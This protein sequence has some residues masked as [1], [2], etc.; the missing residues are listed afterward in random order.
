MSHAR[1]KALKEDG[2]TISRKAKKSGRASGKLTPSDGSPMTSLLA[3]P[4]PSHSKN[5]S[6]AASDVSEEDDDASSFDSYNTYGDEFLKNFQDHPNGSDG[7]EGSGVDSAALIEQ[8]QDRKNNNG[9]TRERHLE[10]YNSYL[11]TRYAPETHEWLEDAASTLAELFL[12]DSNRGPTARER[13]LSLQA[14]CLTISTAESV[15]IYA[16]GS[17]TLKAILTDDDDDDCRVCAVN[18]LCMTTLYGGGGEEEALD[19]MEYFIEIIQSDGETIGAYDN[20]VLVHA[21]IQG[22]AF[23]ASHVDD[24]SDF[25]EVAM[26]SFVDQLESGDAEVQAA[27]ANC[28]A[29]IFEA[30]RNHEDENGEPFQLPYDPQR[31]VGRIGELAKVT[32]RATS[33]KERRG[34]RESLVS[35]VTSLEQG[36]GPFF[37]TVLYMPLGD[38]MKNIPKWMRVPDGRAME[39]YRHKLRLGGSV[40]IVDTWSLYCRVNMMKTIFRGGLQRHAFDNPIVSSCLDDANWESNWDEGV[41]AK[42]TKA[43]QRA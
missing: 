17:K 21:I 35:V 3:S 24:F 9:E 37:S 33:R 18:A 12:K 36:V 42:L 6:R 43:R 40:A 16:T 4:S 29:L 11:R 27:S 1:V 28:I 31:L 39:G 23:V 19:L 5:P 14:Y 20:V 8:L 10:I 7:G 2:K 41:D 26:D 38:D 13:L 30:S 22:W 15:D 32:A 25:A 34:L